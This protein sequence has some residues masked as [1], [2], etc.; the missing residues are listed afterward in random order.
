[1]VIHRVDLITEIIFH[2]SKYFFLDIAYLE[3]C[4]IVLDRLKVE[5]KREAF[6]SYGNYKFWDEIN[7][8]KQK[9][10]LFLNLSY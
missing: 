8:T 9:L 1:M 10:L 3:L 2:L 5:L 6:L 7:I 4:Y